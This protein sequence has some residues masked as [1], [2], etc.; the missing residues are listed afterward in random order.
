MKVQE[1][2]DNFLIAYITN[3]ISE[4]SRYLSDSISIQYSN[5]GYRT[6]KQQV[7]EALKWNRSDAVI[8]DSSLPNVIKLSNKE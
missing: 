5:I 3:D 4:C 7:L 2:I 6:G 1:L 8:N